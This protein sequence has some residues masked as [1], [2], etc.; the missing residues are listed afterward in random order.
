MI[1]QVASY[2][3]QSYPGETVDIV[4]SLVP[5]RRKIVFYHEMRKGDQLVVEATCNYLLI[6]S[7]GKPQLIP[8]HLTRQLEQPTPRA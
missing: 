5:S 1:Q 7:T 8:T 3:G 2:R 6:S 4:T